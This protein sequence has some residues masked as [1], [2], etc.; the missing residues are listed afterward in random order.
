V[1]LSL[2]DGGRVAGADEGMAGWST[3]A[4]GVTRAVLWTRR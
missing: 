2:D 3:T 4:A 1:A